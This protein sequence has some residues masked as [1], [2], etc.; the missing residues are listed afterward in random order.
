M[1]CITLM[2]YLEII[3]EPFIEK[4]DMCSSKLTVCTASICVRAT[5]SE[6]NAL[7]TTAG[8]AAFPSLLYTRN[9]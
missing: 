9:R 5:G 8:A 3:K 4:D 1:L 2:L 6:M 7:I